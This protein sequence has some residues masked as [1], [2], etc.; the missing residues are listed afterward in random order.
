MNAV[1]AASI[2]H[3]GAYTVGDV[4]EFLAGKKFPCACSSRREEALT[5]P[6]YDEPPYVG[7]YGVN[8]D[9]KQFV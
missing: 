8:G 9:V 4:K 6:N 3:F 1:L 2:F 7:C 5:F